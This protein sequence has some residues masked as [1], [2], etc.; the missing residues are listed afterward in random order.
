MIQPI[1]Y[2]A[3]LLA[4]TTLVAACGGGSKSVLNPGAN[5]LPY[6]VAGLSADVNTM[7]TTYS[8]VAFTGDGG[9]AVWQD[10]SG[11]VSAVSTGVG[12]KNITITIINSS[13]IDV[14]TGSGNVR[15]TRQAGT[16]TNVGGFSGDLW[17][18][19]SGS[20][21][22]IFALAGDAGA[23]TTLNS[24]FFGYIEQNE[25]AGGGV[26]DYS[27]T[28]IVSGFETLPS[29]VTATLPTATYTGPAALYLRQTTVGGIANKVALIENSSGTNLTANFGA[30]TL[31]GTLSGTTDTAL[32][33][34]PIVLT[35]TGATITPGNNSFSGGF[36]ESGAN[37][38]TL[39][40]LQQI[41]GNFY[42]QNAAEIGGIISTGVAAGGPVTGATVASGFFLGN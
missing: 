38:I 21:Q 29:E 12:D 17:R 13:T 20:L 15:F 7:T 33:N 10:N 40:G 28:F 22:G 41:S 4:A 14:N 19:T 1:G 39:N 2:R 9:S 36:T 24:I 3:T 35:L 26:T 23:P 16:P 5:G 30:G 34:E 42:G 27:D 37:T 11:T 18:N 8:G 31:T 6:A 32:G 25:A